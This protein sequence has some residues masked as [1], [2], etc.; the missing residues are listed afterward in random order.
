[1][2]TGHLVARLQTALHRDIHLDH[3]LHAGLQL[4]ALR[5]LLF[6]QFERG[7]EFGTLLRQTFLDLF[8]LGG[9]FIIGHANIEPLMRLDAVQIF[10]A[11]LG[12]LGQFFRSAVGC[13]AM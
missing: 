5:Q 6:L 7:I 1:M 9:H 10:L 3:L 11:Q 2:T 13:L 12:A 4:V 8:H